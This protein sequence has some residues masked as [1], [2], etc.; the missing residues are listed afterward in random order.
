MQ[1]FNGKIYKNKFKEIGMILNKLEIFDMEKILLLL[2][3]IKNNFKQNSY[4]LICLKKKLKHSN[5]YQKQKYL[6]F[7]MINGK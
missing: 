2:K 7:K 6:A 4:K 5:H 3:I 1:L